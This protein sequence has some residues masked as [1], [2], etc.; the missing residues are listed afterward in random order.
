M[1]VNRDPILKPLYLS[2]YEELRGEAYVVLKRRMRALKRHQSR[3]LTLHN[4]KGTEGLRQD[5][6][7]L[8]IQWCP[9]NKLHKK[10]L[11]PVRFLVK[12]SIFLGMRT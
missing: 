7:G 2:R 9:E 1:T 6:P 4:E 12:P 11:T 5:P 10:K 8:S 3:L